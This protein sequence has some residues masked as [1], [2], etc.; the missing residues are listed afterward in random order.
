MIKYTSQRWSSKTH[1]TK[2]GNMQFWKPL[3]T[4]VIALWIK[5]PYQT[6]RPWL[7]KAKFPISTLLETM[8]YTCIWLCD[9]G[10]R[11]AGVN[12]Y[13]Q[14]SARIPLP[15]FF[16]ITIRLVKCYHG[17]YCSSF[18]GNNNIFKQQPSHVSSLT[19]PCKQSLHISMTW[20]LVY[21]K[22]TESDWRNNSRHV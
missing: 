16:S 5:N 14:I 22:N 2:H 10:C 9:D 18:Q 11:I 19:T 1:P 21:K 12:F 4:F 3:M 13:I 7:T 6:S 15:R 20:W 17:I 8:R